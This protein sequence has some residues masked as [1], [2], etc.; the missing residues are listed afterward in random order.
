MQDPAQS[1]WPRTI[2]IVG[3]LGPHAHLAFER[4]L[5]ASVGVVGR[6][7]DYPPWIVSS[8]PATP[9]RTAAILSDGA[10][11]VP[12]LVASLK[13]LE[14]RA[15][16]AVVVCNTAHVFLAEASRR[17]SIPIL[18]MI[19]EAI[20]RISENVEP[21]SSIGLLATNG[22][23]RSRIYPDTA[24]SAAPDLN[25]RSL[26]DLPG[27]DELQDSLVMSSIYGGDGDGG[28]KAG[29]T[30]DQRTGEAYAERLSAAAEHLFEDGC[31]AVVLGCTEIS[32]AM[33][34]AAG[35][36]PRLVD[37]MRLAAERCLRIAAGEASLP[38]V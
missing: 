13:N 15:D 23:L 1:R 7:Q 25:W 11:P 4:Q 14:G 37:P 30:H 2:G 34:G 31:A 29:L 6:D 20:E 33:S 26:L 22:T 38:Q 3:G 12:W 18:H 8:L 10:S 21:G 27:G 17:V 28:L 9:D 35:L 24:A 36:D 5:L 19:R 16:F 32:L